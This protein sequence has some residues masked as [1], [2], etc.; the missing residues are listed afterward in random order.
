M[1]PPD[2]DIPTAVI[3]LVR[4]HGDQAAIHAAMEADKQLEAGDLEGA[5]HSRA[6]LAA[7]R[8]MVEPEGVQQ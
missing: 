4:E 7:V 2:T 1:P 6:V 3:A 5:T 8:R